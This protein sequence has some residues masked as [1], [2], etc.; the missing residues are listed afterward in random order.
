VTG[1]ARFQVFNEPEW[2]LA[3]IVAPW[4]LGR[5]RNGFCMY[6]SG[7]LAHESAHTTQ[8]LDPL[9]PLRCGEG[10]LHSLITTGDPICG[11]PMRQGAAG[12]E[13]GGYAFRF[14]GR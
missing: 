4:R 6:R 13:E 8:W 2:I 12:V 5:H 3:Q 7:W 1:L 14:A 11:I 10:A 9:F